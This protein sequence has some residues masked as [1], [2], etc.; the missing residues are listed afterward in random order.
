MKEIV[1]PEVRQEVLNRL[2]RAEGQLRGVQRM[3]EQGQPCVDVASQM[4]AV[5]R[6]LDSTYVRLTLGYVREQLLEIPA[7]RGNGAAA[8][9]MDGLLGEV[10]Q[11]LAK[12]R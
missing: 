7:L 10:Q 6:A 11:L 4:T 2:R 3:I 8:N 9:E 5:R 1:D 12:V